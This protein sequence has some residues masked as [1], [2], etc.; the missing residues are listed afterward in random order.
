MDL[1]SNEAVVT[2]PT[3]NEPS[4]ADGSRRSTKSPGRVKQFLLL[5]EFGGLASAVVAFGV[6]AILARNNGF[7]T[8]AGLSSWVNVAGD[9]GVIAGPVGLLMIVGEF[10]LSVGSVVGATSVAIALCSGVYNLSP[11]VGVLIA[12]AIGLAVGLINGLLVV[13]TKVPSIIV[14]LSTMLMVYGGSIA[15][16]N[17]L[18]GSAST[19]VTIGA[20]ARL[21]FGSN[22]DGFDVCIAWWLGTALIATYVMRK[23]RFGN[24]AYATGGHKETARNTGVPTGMVKVVLM[25]CTSLGAV[26]SGIFLTMSGQTGAPSL[27]SSYNL[28]AIAV[29]VI[30]G[31]LLSGGYGSPLGTIFGTVTYA[32]VSIGIFFVGWDADLAS[33]FIGLFLLVTMLAN[34]YLKRAAG[35]RV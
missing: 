24:W 21:V 20:S 13:L 26:L 8:L 12:A 9:L 4:T 23:T 1:Q 25:V 5:P 11:W 10:D 18:T 22:W 30:G 34:N 27:G 31:V 28:L 7:L 17:S 19:S 29:V 14:T 35:G 6:F 16:S 33:L 3:E 15:I 32:V 2:S